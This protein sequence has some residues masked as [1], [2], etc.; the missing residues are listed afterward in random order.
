MVDALSHLGV[1]HMEI[2]MT[3]G[4]VWNVVKDKGAALER[5]MR[6]KG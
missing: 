4:R 1:T 2:P 3:P 6:A 5:S